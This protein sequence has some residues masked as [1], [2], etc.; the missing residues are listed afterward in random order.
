[1]TTRKG[2][3]LAGGNATRL[4]PATLPFGKPFLPVA[5]KP[6]IF[7]P[8]TV[9]LQSGIKDILV[10]TA[11][12]DKAL[13]H[14]LLGDGSQFGATIS[15]IEQP[16]A[17]GIA[18]AFIVGESF[19]AGDP[20]CLILCDNLFH[21]EGLSDAIEAG[22]KNAATGATIFCQYVNNPAAY[23]VVDFDESG[24]VTRL[25]EKPAS[26]VSNWAATGLYIYDGRASAL[27]KTLPLSKRGEL[28]I[29]D[30]NSL[31]L[32]QGAL[33]SIKFHK[34]FLW[35][36]LGTYSSILEASNLIVNKESRDN[37]RIGCPYIA[38]YRAGY[39]NSK[40]LLA[41]ADSLGNPYYAESLRNAV[42]ASVAVKK[43]SA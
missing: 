23:G 7:Y 32:Q 25:V 31:Y 16:I 1:M 30:L 17:R 40:D 26:F 11:P 42:L 20:V 8:L 43:P 5:D 22:W 13:F 24:Q 18:D 27:A 19:I 35:L 15:Y 34:D 41:I 29:T 33:H 38:A 12:R 10:I 6:M 36:D 2:I 14:A 9:L 37:I 21:G 39:I 4:H 3:I 28:E